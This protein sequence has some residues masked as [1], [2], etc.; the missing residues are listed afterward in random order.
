[1]RPIA[2]PRAAAAALLLIAAACS[3]VTA[4]QQALLPAMRLAWGSI[5][6]EVVAG[7]SELR[8]PVDDATV[9]LGAGDY[10]AIAAIDWPKMRAAAEAS[11]AADVA[12]SKVG[13]AVAKSLQAR[14][15]AFGNSLTKFLERQ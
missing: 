6:A 5:A 1:M 12:A 2:H 3:G 13:P 14:L 10:A 9:A 15:D 7:N 8:V 11:I 4:R